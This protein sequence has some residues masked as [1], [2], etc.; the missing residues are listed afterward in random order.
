MGLE[1]CISSFQLPVPKQVILL[2][3]DRSAHLVSLSFCGQRPQTKPSGTQSCPSNHSHCF[4]SPPFSDIFF[5]LG[6]FLLFWF[7][8]ELLYLLYSLPSLLNPV[9]LHSWRPAK[10]NPVINNQKISLSFLKGAG[11]C[12]P[13]SISQ[14]MRGYSYIQS[15][16][17]IR[18]RELPFVSWL[19][20]LTDSLLLWR[21][22]G[23]K[24]EGGVSNTPKELK[25]RVPKA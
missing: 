1:S 18:K 8:S 4:S 6:K 19:K 20:G 24:G 14:E 21:A 15:F 23:G 10:P 12:N 13:H 16:K 2:I 25:L 9:L 17:C 3:K 7:S 22:K 11:E 5:T